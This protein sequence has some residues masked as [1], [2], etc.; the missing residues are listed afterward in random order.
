[1]RKE[2]RRRREVDLTIAAAL[3]PGERLMEERPTQLA[4]EVTDRIRDLAPA[5][6]A[7]RTVSLLIEDIPEALTQ[8]GSG[9]LLAIDD[10]VFLVSAAHVLKHAIDGQVWINPVADGAKMIPLEKM[11]VVL[12]NDRFKVDFGFIKLPDAPARELAT[13]KKFIHV[14]DVDISLPA[15]YWYAVL[16]YPHE[17]N[18]YRHTEASVPSRPMYYATRLH[19]V[20]KDPLTDFDPAINLALE[21]PIYGSGE[22]VT[23]KLSTIPDARGMSGS[24]I[25]RLYRYSDE[26]LEWSKEQIRIAGV[27]HTRTGESGLFHASSGQAA[28]VGVHFIH[29]VRTIRSAHPDLADAINLAQ[30]AL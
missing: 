25:W 16:G 15:G 27:L 8:L 13:A 24:G 7:E 23:R 17:L 6:L 2:H 22:A 1:M 21:Y 28:L 9:L 19:N 18:V 20:T 10:S 12:T 11:K 4:H 3:G 26:A 29:V 30:P 5:W 14:H